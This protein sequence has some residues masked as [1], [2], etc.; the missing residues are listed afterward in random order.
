MHRI[1]ITELTELPWHSAWLCPGHPT[2]PSPTGPNRA[3]PNRAHACTKALAA[4][5]LGAALHAPRPAHRDRPAAL[6]AFKRMPMQGPPEPSP[7]EPIELQRPAA[8]HSAIADVE[9]KPGT[10]WGV[11][12]YASPHTPRAAALAPPEA[13]R[14][15]TCTCTDTCDCARSTNPSGLLEAPTKPEGVIMITYIEGPRARR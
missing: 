1:T 15:S 11:Q 6:K 4:N 5:P 14:R 10:A 13:S 2:E 9:T 3:K 12:T 8:R 7:T